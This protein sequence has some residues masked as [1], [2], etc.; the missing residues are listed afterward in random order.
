MRI[1]R[2]FWTASLFLAL[3]AIAAGLWLRACS[4]GAQP[5]RPASLPMVFGIIQPQALGPKIVAASIT[6][7]DVHVG[8]IQRLEVQTEE[9][10]A[11]TSVEAR[12][13]LD[14]E[15]KLLP[16]VPQG[17]GKYAAEWTVYDT[18][19]TTYRT[20]FIVT[21]AAGGRSEVALAWSDACNIP[22]SGDWISFGDC[23]INEPDG[24]ENGN[25]T[26]GSGHTLVLNADFAV[27]SGFSFSIPVGGAI[28][29][30]S[31]AALRL[32]NIWVMDF[33]GD[34]Y[35][36]PDDQRLQDD[37]P[38]GDGWVRRAAAAALGD[39]DDGNSALYQIIS[40]AIDRDSDGYVIG[41]NLTTR[42][43]GEASPYQGRTY[44]YS[45]GV[46][47]FYEWIG[48]SSIAGYHDANDDNP[49]VH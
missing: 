27:N 2:T 38:E 43:V 40:G 12:I 5:L 35:A 34:G 31:G 24:I 18:H 36:G 45:S 41:D 33:D 44:Y 13:E 25:A 7:Q 29:L 4:K 11:I 10:V 37:I 14:H 6:P 46:A 30:A 48:A 21:D 20:T 8:D 47:V 42:C 19:E 26:I 9:G 1:L 15:V 49:A 28:V 17:G 22:I 16:L 23:T 39:C 32:T 3:L